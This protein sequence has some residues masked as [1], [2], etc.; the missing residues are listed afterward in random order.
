[1][2]EYGGTLLPLQELQKPSG[3]VRRSSVEKLVV[4]SGASYMFSHA[5]NVIVGQKE[6]RKLMA[7]VFSVAG[8][9]CSNCGQ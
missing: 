4:K 1:M 5:M 3:P 8:I 7:G 6:D 2:A 9:H